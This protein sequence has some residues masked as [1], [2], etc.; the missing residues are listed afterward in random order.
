ML[1]AGQVAEADAVCRDLV[2]KYPRQAEPLYQLGV[3]LCL[4]GRVSA[5][6]PFWRRAADAAP[7]EPQYKRALAH[8]LAEIGQL[9]AAVEVARSAVE[10]APSSAE[11]HLQLANLFRRAKQFDAAIEHYRQA[12]DL[13]PDSPAAYGD[14]GNLLSELGT[15]RGGDSVFRGSREPRSRFRRRVGKSRRDA[16]RG[17]PCP[18]GDCGVSPRGDQVSAAPHGMAHARQRAG[19][20]GPLVRGGCG[21]RH[22]NCQQSGRTQPQGAVQPQPGRSGRRGIS[23]RGG[24]NIACDTPSSRQ[25]VIWTGL[26]RWGGESLEGKTLLV[27]REQGIGTQ[28]MFSGYLEPAARHAGHVIAEC[29]G[30]LRE[31][32][33]RSYAGVEFRTTEEL[34]GEQQSDVARVQ[35]L[36]GRLDV[37]TAIGDLP[38]NLSGVVSPDAGPVAPRL[39]PDRD[40]IAKWQR[41]LAELPGELNVG[42]SWR[43][44]S[45]SGTRRKRSTNLCDWQ[46]VLA[47]PGVNFVNLQ[48][49][50][51]DDELASLQSGVELARWP[52]FD[53]TAR[54][55]RFGGSFGGARSRDHDRQLDG[56]SRRRGRRRDVD[57]A[58]GRRGLAVDEPSDAFRVVS[59][60]TTDS[61]SCRRDLGGFAGTDCGRAAIGRRRGGR[62]RRRELGSRGGVETTRG[63]APN[64]TRGTAQ[65]PFPTGRLDVGR[66]SILLICSGPFDGTRRRQTLEMPETVVTAGPAAAS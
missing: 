30:R 16:L 22:R 11:G 33:A 59:G 41:R 4:Q 35:P 28:V 14:L 8:G 62:T 52:D 26:P 31:L 42:I 58:A 17:G 15:Y 53:P 21:L 38:S 27:R 23:P 18:R 13:A 45:T 57:F 10:L 19:G 54:S 5:A 44:G 39:M 37:E 29:D 1:A 36:D 3:I 9:E 49:G 7:T 25:S 60:G 50:P 40:L 56:A 32:L 6:V 48:Y 20:R 24:G 66:F 65:R 2:R 34:F 61:T 51:I 12:I 64:A 47:T 46:G 55:R 63:N 43:G